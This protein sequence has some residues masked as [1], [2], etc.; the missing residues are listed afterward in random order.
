MFGICEYTKKRD[1]QKRISLF[2]NGTLPILMQTERAFFFDVGSVRGMKN[3]L[4][5]SLPKNLYIYEEMLSY[6][7]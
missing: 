7:D 4:F 2:K 6:L 1:V 3:I 5:F